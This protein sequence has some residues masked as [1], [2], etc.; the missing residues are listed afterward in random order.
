[1]SDSSLLVADFAPGLG[2]GRGKEKSLEALRSLPE[3]VLAL[4]TDTALRAMG[5][6]VGCSGQ[7]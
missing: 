6:L 1:M 2:S 5:V 3:G 4:I 7:V